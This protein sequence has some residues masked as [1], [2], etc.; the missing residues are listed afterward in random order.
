MQILHPVALLVPWLDSHFPLC[1]LSCSGP[2]VKADVKKGEASSVQMLDLWK[3]EIPSLPWFSPNRVHCL[4]ASTT[5]HQPWALV[6]CRD[7]LCFRNHT[8][9]LTWVG[10]EWSRGKYLLRILSGWGRLC[11]VCL[12]FLQAPLPW[13]GPASFPPVLNTLCLC[14]ILPALNVSVFLPFYPVCA[15]NHQHHVEKKMLILGLSPPGRWN[16]YVLDCH[17]YLLK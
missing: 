6:V 11:H 14:P 2:K 3:Q 15:V 5:A 1:P 13:A 9:P 4:L 16:T 8:K 12:P 10:M 7:E 17:S